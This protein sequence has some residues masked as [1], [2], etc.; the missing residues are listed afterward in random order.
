M[1]DGPERQ[2]LMSE[3]KKLMIAYLPYKV[4]VHRIFT[5]LAQ[6]RVVG[7][8]HNL[9]VATFL[10]YIDVDLAEWR[11]RQGPAGAAASGASP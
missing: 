4:H 1:P 3:A 6:P 8:H 11:R 9:L 10:K 7:Y 5:D 2:A